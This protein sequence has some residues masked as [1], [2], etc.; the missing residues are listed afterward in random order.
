MKTGEEP[1][2][3]SG[4]HLRLLKFWQWAY[5]DLLNNTT[6]GIL[7]EFV[8]Q[9]A[10]T[11]TSKPRTEWDRFDVLYRGVGIEVKSSAYIQ[12]WAQEQASKIIFDIAPKKSYSSESR[13][14][15]TEASRQADIYVFSLL[16]WPEIE[17]CNPLD[18]NQWTFFILSTKTINSER[19]AQ[20]SLSLSSL[21]NLKPIEA[22]YPSLKS[23]IDTIIDTQNL[24]V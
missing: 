2:L 13:K 22:K 5:S 4:N 15:S 6:R 14:Y 10:L 24:A 11:T 7:A 8:V 3:N 23:S 21:R 18:L 20:K 1:F 9:S 19:H 16:D 17:G 12:S